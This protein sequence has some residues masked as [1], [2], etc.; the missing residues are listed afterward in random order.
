MAKTGIFKMPSFTSEKRKIVLVLSG[1]A[2]L[3]LG[4]IGALDVIEREFDIQCIIGTSMGSIVGG[5][6][7]S[8]MKPVEMVEMVANLGA[9]EYLG[10]FKVGL[11]GTGVL[12]IK[13]LDKYLTQKTGGVRIE[14]LPKPYAA[15]SFDILRRKTV[16]ITKGPLASAMCASSC[17]P[18][19]FE[20]FESKGHVLMDGGTEHA[21]PRSF[22]DVFYK[23]LDVVAVSALPEIGEKPD[24]IELASYD[25]NKGFKQNYLYTSL[26]TGV[27]N[28]SAQALQSVLYYKPYLYVNVNAEGLRSW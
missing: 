15:I 27:Y 5:L 10:L 23:S 13:W 12:D 7:L 19:A 28:Q 25:K 26:R 20:P 17:V 16:V 9:I 11:P 22:A 6:Y 24:E 18:L 1:G 4:H 21:L 14:E 8:G 3:G 2:A